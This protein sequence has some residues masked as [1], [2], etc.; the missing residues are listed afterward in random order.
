MKEA[1]VVIGI[2]AILVMAV[3][4]LISAIQFAMLYAMAK[5]I[6]CNYRKQGVNVKDVM[7]ALKNGQVYSVQ[8]FDG[9]GHFLHSKEWRWES[10]IF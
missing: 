9:N 5:D 1:M 8:T 2:I 4:G 6:V 10:L 7:L 3:I